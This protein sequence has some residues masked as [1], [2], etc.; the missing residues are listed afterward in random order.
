MKK[1]SLLVLSAFLAVSNAWS[2]TPEQLDQLLQQIKNDISAK[3]LSSP[4]GNNA[5][6]KITQ[7]RSEAPFDYRWFRSLTIGVRP[8][9]RYPLRLVKRAS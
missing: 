7:F 8:M 6:E 4:E 2:A 3:R 5:L 9:L 1:I